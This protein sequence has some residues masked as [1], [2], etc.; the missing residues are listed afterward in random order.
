LGFN[1]TSK[2]SPGWPQLVQAIGESFRRALRAAGMTAF[3]RSSRLREL[4]TQSAE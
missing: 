4:L 3:T 2:G 1:A